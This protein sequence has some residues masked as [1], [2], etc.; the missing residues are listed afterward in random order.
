MKIAEQENKSSFIALIESS[1][2]AQHIFRLPK[3]NKGCRTV[4]GHCPTEFVNGDKTI[5]DPVKEAGR[6]WT[7][8]NLIIK[9]LEDI[10]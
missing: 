1:F 5:L 7:I 8:P 2:I 6:T 10:Y 3:F 9:T 4:K